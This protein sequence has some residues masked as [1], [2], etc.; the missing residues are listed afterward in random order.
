MGG[1][2]YHVGSFQFPS[3]FF[4]PAQR[5]L[6]V[7]TRL[8][9]GHMRQS[10][11]KKCDMR[12][13]VWHAAISLLHVRDCMWAWLWDYLCISVSGFACNRAVCQYGGFRLI[14]CQK[15]TN[16]WWYNFKTSEWVDVDCVSTLVFF[17][18]L[19]KSEQ[20]TDD[21]IPPRMLRNLS[22]GWWSKRQSVFDW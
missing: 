2:S 17:P 21:I 22:G 16:T 6:D 9:C 4:R 1:R 20:A 7:P 12:N 19:I 15:R 11:S 3:F 13:D 8:S 10:D 18:F 14:S 5:C